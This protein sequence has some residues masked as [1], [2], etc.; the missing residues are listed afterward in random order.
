MLK[1]IHDGSLSHP[2]VNQRE[3]CYKI[4]DL[5]RQRQSEYK[6][7]LKA[8]QIMGKVNTRCLRLL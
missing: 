8:T 6:G 1:D 7:A 5:I 3:A 4:R 2:N